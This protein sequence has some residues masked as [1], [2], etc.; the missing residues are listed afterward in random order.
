MRFKGKPIV[1]HARLPAIAERRGAERIGSREG[2]RLA[3]QHNRHNRRTTKIDSQLSL[4]HLPLCGFGHGSDLLK[5]TA[6]RGSDR[7]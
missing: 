2:R 1:S 6:V 3:L 4:Q 5:E 7:L